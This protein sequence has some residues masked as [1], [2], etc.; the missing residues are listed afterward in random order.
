M[1]VN[2]K[3]QHLAEMDQLR[4][5]TVRKWPKLRA[6][7][8]LAWLCI[9]SLCNNRPNYLEI[10][11]SALAADQGKADHR[12]G[13]GYL[14]RLEDA[15]LIEIEKSHDRIWKIKVND[16]LAVEKKHGLKK[17]DVDPQGTL[18]PDWDVEEEP[19]NM[20]L[21]F[22]SAQHP[23]QDVASTS[24]LEC[25]GLVS[26]RISVERATGLYSE[27]QH[28]AQDVARGRKVKTV[29]PHIDPEEGGIDQDA[30]M[31]A[32]MAVAG[33]MD[34]FT[35]GLTQSYEHR[36]KEV[37]KL[38]RM[39]L[40]TVGPRLYQSVA[41][42]VAGDVVGLKFPETV[43]RRLMDSFRKFKDR[44][45]NEDGSKQ[46]PQD[47]SIWFVSNAKTNYREN[48]LEW[49]GEKA[50]VPVDKSGDIPH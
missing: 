11:P 33:A 48:R 21:P 37:R 50:A 40:D 18:A 31:L 10:S 1:E 26:E 9:W 5:A 41:E 8:K 42:K 12:A 22:T 13:M 7:P 23:A 44:G 32:G 3:R 6:E 27:K 47:W 19:A 4:W 30:K 16:P 39:I 24:V 43:F 34:R 17:A 49:G 29:G 25:S 45:T 38:A 15:G 35:A 36:D 20:A 2:S 28:P 46:T 14:T